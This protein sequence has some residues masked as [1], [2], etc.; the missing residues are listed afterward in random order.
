MKAYRYKPLT[1]YAILGT[2]FSGVLL[3]VIA[4]FI[5]VAPGWPNCQSDKGQALLQPPYGECCVYSVSKGF[6]WQCNRT[7]TQKGAL[8]LA[9]AIPLTLLPLS[10]YI[11]V[12]KKEEESSSG[13]PKFMYRMI[14]GLLAGFMIVGVLAGLITLLYA[15]FLLSKI[16]T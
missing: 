12:T 6:S 4:T 3:A 15:L 7:P 10:P 9:I 8:L 16:L 1:S 11:F 2:Y 13:W 5:T 14:D